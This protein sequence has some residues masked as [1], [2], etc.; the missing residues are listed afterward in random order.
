VFEVENWAVEMPA[1]VATS[2]PPCQA[3]SRPPALTQSRSA[4]LPFAPSACSA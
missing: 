3:T 1:F 2:A 4:F